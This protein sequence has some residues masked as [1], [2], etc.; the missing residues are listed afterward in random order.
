MKAWL[1]AA[2]LLASFSS[3]AADDTPIAELTLSDANLQQCIQDA[4]SNSGARTIAEL[5]SLVCSTKGDISLKEL[6]QFPQLETILIRGGNIRG[7]SGL[8]ESK[9]VSMVLLSRANITDFG[10]L[11]NPNVDI[12]LSD[13]TAKDWQQITQLHVGSILIQNTNNCAQYHF[14]LN[15]EDVALLTQESTND[16]FT[17]AVIFG[18]ADKLAIMLDCPLKALK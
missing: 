15:R 17:D 11:D 2:S 18:Y 10:T 6:D 1:I 14:L 4:A 12:T 5:D 7:F 8:A 3:F 13:V 16:E 9:N